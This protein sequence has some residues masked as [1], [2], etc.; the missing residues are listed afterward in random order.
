MS[1]QIRTTLLLTIIADRSDYSGFFAKQQAPRNSTNA[2]TP[3]IIADGTIS[4]NRPQ[5][6]L[7]D[8]TEQN[9]QWL[10]TRSR[11]GQTTIEEADPID[12]GPL[13][14]VH[15]STSI[16]LDSESQLYGLTSSTIALNTPEPE[17]RVY[18][19]P[20][21]ADPQ[22]QNTY[23][24]TTET[25]DKHLEGRSDL[26]PNIELDQ[27][28]PVLISTSSENQMLYMQPRCTDLRNPTRV[29][30]D[31]WNTFDGAVSAPIQVEDVRWNSSN[32]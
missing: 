23:P 1:S 2:N 26:Q 3:S 19:I 32:I 9:N 17:S 30:P 7:T 10:S 22:C 4:Q 6:C 12:A 21:A 16:A 20:S 25:Q 31:Q 8:A 15:D 24:V 14:N 27:Q 11:M 5:Q 28:I 29:A 18:Q 13:A